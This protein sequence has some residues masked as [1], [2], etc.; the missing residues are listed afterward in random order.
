MAVLRGGFKVGSSGVVGLVD[1]TNIFGGRI[2]VGGFGGEKYF[3]IFISF[4]PFLYLSPPGNETVYPSLAYLRNIEEV[5]VLSV[6]LTNHRSARKRGIVGIAGA[7]VGFSRLEGANVGHSR[8]KGANVRPSRIKGANVGGG[9]RKE[10]RVFL[11][12]TIVMGF[13]LG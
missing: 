3:P 9:V 4:A 10:E 12:H 13:P 6:A 2:I 11:I 8:I 1:G 7:K 5:C